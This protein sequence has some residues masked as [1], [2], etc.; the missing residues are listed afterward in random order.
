MARAEKIHRRLPGR[1]ASLASYH[2]LWL[3]PDH[4]LSV[5]TTGYS[6]EYKRFYYRDL[7]AIVFRKTDSW[8]FWNLFLGIVSA[9]VVFVALMSSSGDALGGWI[10][11]AACL[12]VLFLINLLRG[13]TCACHV[14]TAVQAERLP[15][16]KRL[17]IARKVVAQLKPLIE[18]AQGPLAPEQL[19]PMS[20]PAP[21][22]GPTPAAAQPSREANGPATTVSTADAPQ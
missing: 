9:L 11:L 3:G 15:T 4:L 20:P 14:R 2:R 19:R 17:R 10:G 12:F 16:L 8:R 18:A 1:A 7:Q 21:V 5:R 22:G 6:E 13:P